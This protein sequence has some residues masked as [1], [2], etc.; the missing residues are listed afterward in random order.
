MPE[1]EMSQRKKLIEVAQKLEAISPFTF[2]RHGAFGGDDGQQDIPPFIAYSIHRRSAKVH[3]IP[4]GDRRHVGRGRR[5]ERGRLMSP[6]AV[7][8]FALGC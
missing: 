1:T 2:F 3:L 6:V 7:S 4:R 5:I 8:Y